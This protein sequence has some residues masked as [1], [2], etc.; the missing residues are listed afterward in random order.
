MEE[1]MKVT[2]IGTSHGVPAEDRYCTSILLEVGENSYVFDA[3]APLADQII[4]M[5][6][7]W[8]SIRAVFNTH[9]HGDHFLGLL[10]FLDLAN[11]Y[12]GGTNMDVFVPRE[13]QVKFIHDMSFVTENRPL[14]ERI[15]VQKF[16]EGKVYEDDY[17]TVTAD[18]TDHLNADDDFFSYAFT[19]TEKATG[20]SFLFA[21]DCSAPLDDVKRIT[22]GNSYDLTVFECAHFPYE[23]IEECFAALD[24]KRAAVIHVY[25][26]DKYEAI[27]ASRSKYPFEILAPNDG[28]SVIL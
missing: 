28:D 7:D 22:V 12:Y 27:A 24:T 5:G 23:M 25:P 4:R 16:T 11:W 3:G 20:K 18:R 14:S 21:G 10:S 9:P 17:I 6:V 13:S 1:I 19:V 2:F 8:N 26:L 15:N